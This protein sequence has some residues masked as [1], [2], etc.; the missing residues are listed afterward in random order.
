[1]RQALLGAAM[2]ILV[3]GG[4]AGLGAQVTVRGEVLD[5]LTGLPVP[6]ALVVVDRPQR[7]VRTD[8]LGYFALE[9]LPRGG[10][11]ALTVLRV[12]YRSVSPTVVEAEEGLTLTV[13]LTPQP[14]ELEG[15]TATA[16]SSV[17]EEARRTGHPFD[18][19]SREDIEDVRD[20]AVDVLDVIQHKAGPRMRVSI[21]SGSAGVGLVEYCVESTRKAPS[22]AVWGERAGCNGALIALDGMVLVPSTRGTSVIHGRVLAEFLSLDPDDIES[23]RFMHPMEACFRWGPLGVYG[24][25]MVETRRGGG[26]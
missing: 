16:R 4:G 22:L 14:V 18:H 7:S 13:H 8:R 9:D 6:D 19:V 17:A 21:R 10:A 20:V 15:L 24:A 5:A 26:R 1:M 11:V 3:S 2:A 25:L 12:G 23:V